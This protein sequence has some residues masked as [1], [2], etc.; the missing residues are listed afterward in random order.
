[1][2][3]HTPG[4]WKLDPP[5]FHVAEERYHQ[6]RAGRG[7]NVGSAIDEES[8]FS[9]S[10]WMK[11]SDALLITAA[12]DLLEAAETAYAVMTNPDHDIYADEHKI[13]HA[14][15]RLKVAIAKAKGET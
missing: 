14:I 6:V 15:L 11:K 8:G 12:P 1:M 3:A 7:Y 2:N 10:G 9:I 5:D 13:E 4:P